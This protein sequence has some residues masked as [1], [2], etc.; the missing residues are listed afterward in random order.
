MTRRGY[1]KLYSYH[2]ASATA[3]NFCPRSCSRHA[4]SAAAVPACFRR[5]SPSLRVA[6][7]LLSESSDDRNVQHSS[8]LHRRWVAIDAHRT[9]L[10]P[11]VRGWSSSQPA[12]RAQGPVL[13]SS[14]YMKLHRSLL[15]ASS[16][17]FV[18]SVQSALLPGSPRI[19][20]FRVLIIGLPQGRGKEESLRDNLRV[21]TWLKTP[22][23][24]SISNTPYLVDSPKRHVTVIVEKTKR[25]PGR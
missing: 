14:W 17:V 1:P 7:S 2:R 8:I 6:T 10:V 4:T 23:Q 22:A 25:I 3:A 24:Q 11:R 5:I 19:H 16:R 12:H 18:S 21:A 20:G 15:I 9:F 13:I